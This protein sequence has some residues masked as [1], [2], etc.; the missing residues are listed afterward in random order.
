[1]RL[2]VSHQE[3]GAIGVEDVGGLDDDGSHRVAVDDRRAET[4]REVIEMLRAAVAG[5][6]P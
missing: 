5:G 4:S 2:A 6:H 1:M 3:P